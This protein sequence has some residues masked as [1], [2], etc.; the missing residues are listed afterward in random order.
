MHIIIDGY[1]LIRQSSALR[2]FEHIS[3]EEGRGELLRR[4]ARYKKAKGHKVTVVF[5]GWREGPPAQE[6]S[7]KAGVHVIFTARGE[8]A[9][10]VICRMVEK[11]GEEIVVVT[12]DR[13]VARRAF[14]R[15]NAAVSSQEFEALMMRE[16]ERAFIREKG[17]DE[18]EDEVSSL[19]Q[20]RGSPRRTSKKERRAHQRLKKL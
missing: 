13:P 14:S 11:S 1:N 20:G 8:T 5:D 7:Q 12:S 2:R 15:G 16:E 17:A 18:E 3:L 4:V 6:E 10:E 19:A 9:D